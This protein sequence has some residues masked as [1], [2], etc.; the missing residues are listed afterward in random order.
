MLEIEDLVGA[1]LFDASS[2]AP[3]AILLRRLPAKALVELS[4]L[5]Y[6]GRAADPTGVISHT[7]ALKR[8][9]IG[10]DEFRDELLRSDEFRHR[11][12]RP[13]HR[14]GRGTMVRAL[15]LY[16]R[17]PFEK[18]PPLRQYDHLSAAEFINLDR[19]QFLQACYI[20]VFRRQPD[21]RAHENLLAA[22]E[23]N[24]ACRVD[25]LR[26]LTLQ[27]ASRG[28]FVEID[29]LMLLCDWNS[30]SP[31]PASSETAVL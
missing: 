18:H 3:S 20:K 21:I 13:H 16:E 15:S 17:A 19:A 22:L 25:A 30:P 28:R 2:S 9:A 27:A 7:A 10:A 5:D 8:N 1:E 26:E 23:E 4:Y 29:D 12:I 31:L 6:L 14:L 11:D 24:R